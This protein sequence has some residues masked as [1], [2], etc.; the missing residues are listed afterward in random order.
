M[1]SIL[2]S[3]RIC[4]DSCKLS[5]VPPIPVTP[6][7]LVKDLLDER[8]WTQRVL[9]VILGVEE[10]V[11]NKIISGRRPV[12]APMAILLGEAFGIDAEQFLDLQKSYDLALA[13]LVVRPDPDRNTRAQ[14]FNALPIAEMIKRG[15]LRVDSIKDVPGIERALTKFFGVPSIDEIEVLPHAA[16]KTNVSESVT[17]PQ[18]TWLYRVKRMAEDQLVER[19]SPSSVERAISEVQTLVWSAEEARKVPRIMRENGIRFVVVE[20]LTSAKIDGVCFWLN[21]MAPVVGMSLRHDRI[22]NFFFVLRHELEHARRRH[23]RAE[24][25]VDAEL[26]GERAGIGAGLPE[27]ERL[28][29]EAA[30]DFCV[31]KKKMDKFIAVKAPAF[32]ERDLL[33]F[34]NTLRI[35]PGIVAGQIQRR[36]GRYELFRDHL[37]KIRSIVTASATHDGWGDIAPVD[38]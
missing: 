19:Y 14:L 20:S 25:A 5:A 8:G 27:E 26:E 29:N 1:S 17:P 37:V 33:G 4:A 28:A 35:H 7:Q 38:Q 12:D 16:K 22:D 24:A 9:A 31:P 18:L 11:V 30:A 6:G 13:R 10:T 2:I 36:T 34:A 23:G 21:D 3:L 15:W 32:S